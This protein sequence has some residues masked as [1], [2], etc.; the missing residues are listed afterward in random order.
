[1]H[2]LLTNRKKTNQKDTEDVVGK[3][4]RVTFE[5][6]LPPTLIAIGLAVEYTIQVRSRSLYVGTEINCRVNSVF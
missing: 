1:M 4:A 6:Q 5:S 2:Y 3:L